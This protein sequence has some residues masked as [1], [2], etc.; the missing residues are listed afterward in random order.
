MGLFKTKSNN[1]INDHLINSCDCA[2]KAE[3]VLYPNRSVDG[4]R[5]AYILGHVVKGTLC[6]G[7]EIESYNNRY[8]IILIKKGFDV[9][10]KI[11]TNDH[12][13]LIVTY[14]PVSYYKLPFKKRN[15]YKITSSKAPCSTTQVNAA[16]ETNKESISENTFICSRCKKK[17]SDSESKW[18]N[19]HRF[20]AQCAVPTNS[21]TTTNTNNHTLA[22]LKCS[23][24]E[25]DMR[26]Q[27]LM[28]IHKGG[29][30]PEEAFSRRG[31]IKDENGLWVFP[32]KKASTPQLFTCARCGKNLAIKYM[33]KNNVCVSCATAPNSQVYNTSETNKNPTKC[34]TLFHEGD[35][36]QGND[37]ELRINSDGDITI[38]DTG[39]WPAHR[40]ASNG[41]QCT[42]KLDAD[43]FTKNTVDDFIV[44]LK[45]NYKLA[46]DFNQDFSALKN[47]DDI[48]ALFENNNKT[49]QPRIKFADEQPLGL[50]R[51]KKYLHKLFDV[52]FNAEE[53]QE[54]FVCY[55]TITG[56]PYLIDSQ[57]KYEGH[58]IISSWYGT[59][60]TY[61]Q[62][63]LFAQNYAPTSPLSDIRSDNW[64]EFFDIDNTTQ[65]NPSTYTDSITRESNTAFLSNSVYLG[66]IVPIKLDW[67]DIE[68]APRFNFAGAPHFDE[69]SIGLIKQGKYINHLFIT[70]IND[71]YPSRN[72]GG[73]AE[74]LPEN[75]HSYEGVKRYIEGRGF[76]VY[77]PI[78]EETYNKNINELIV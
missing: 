21:A 65:H 50:Y 20:C 6:T 40:G 1:E 41:G 69:I 42:T 76:S 38:V 47:R 16:P 56:I 34:I 43:Y 39:W 32:G 59:K 28:D 46:K 10:E 33:H 29:L 53:Q 77:Q 26:Y 5:I 44:F 8:K 30:P 9:I 37:I 12:I 2:F 63:A 55:D 68:G 61:E 17:I 51:D 73:T 45:N 64:K 25:E 27:A 3:S 23:A 54:K 52:Y 57:T 70:I 48:K 11:D 22:D 66:S 49:V 19:N 72:G 31:F 35:Q 74:V 78:A 24:S 18:I 13:S 62:V 71:G 58:A 67:R 14:Q 75:H 4:Q 15:V 7:N 60:L 36:Y